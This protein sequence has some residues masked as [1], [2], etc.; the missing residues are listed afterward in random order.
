[1]IGCGL[2]LISGSCFYT[3]NGHHLGNAFIEL[4]TLY[5]DFYPTVGLLSP[6]EVIEANFGQEPFVFDIETAME[7]I[8][9]L[10]Y[11]RSEELTILN[12]QLEQLSI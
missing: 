8:P 5:T 9:G 11:L 6:G 2:N 7:E 4:P 10:N 1:M 12:N 3:K